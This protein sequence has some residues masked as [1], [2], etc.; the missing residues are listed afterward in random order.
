M[1]L[2]LRNRSRPL[3]YAYVATLVVLLVAAFVIHASGTTLAV[4]RI[5]RIV[6]IVAVLGVGALLRRAKVR[7]LTP[8][9]S[10]S[11][12]ATEQAQAARRP[13]VAGR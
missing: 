3:L 12:I 1:F 9:R 2:L 13:G 7:R 10:A 11:P 8:V 5:A 6:V 4:I